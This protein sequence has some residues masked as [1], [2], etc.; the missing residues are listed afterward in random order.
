MVGKCLEIFQLEVGE[1]TDVLSTKHD[2]FTLTVW[3]RL[4]S[5]LISL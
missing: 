1:S 5:L 4:F 3:Y 2:D